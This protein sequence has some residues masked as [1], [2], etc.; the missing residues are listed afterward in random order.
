MNAVT[1]TNHLLGEITGLVVV[2][3]ALGGPEADRDMQAYPPQ[4]KVTDTVNRNVAK[5]AAING[6]PMYGANLARQV[7]D[8]FV[9]A[10]VNRLISRENGRHTAFATIYDAKL[11]LKKKT[12]KRLFVKSLANAGLWVPPPWGWLSA[13]VAYG[14]HL[15]MNKELLEFGIEY[16]ILEGL[17]LL[18]ANPVMREL[19]VKI[20]EDKLI[21]AIAAH[22][23]YLAGRPSLIGGRRP[24][25]TSSSVV[26]Y[27]IEQSLDHLSEVYHV[28]A[29]LFPTLKTQPLLQQLR[30]P[31]VQEAPPSMKGT[32][33]N[34]YE[35]P[36]DNDELA[37]D[38]PTDPV[39]EIREKMAENQ[40]KTERQIQQLKDRIEFLTNLENE[41]KDL[42]ERTGVNDEERKAF[43]DEQQKLSEMISK[44]RIELQE[45]E[46]DLAKI[47]EERR[48]MEQAFAELDKAPAGSG[49]PSAKEKHLALV[50]VPAAGGTTLPANTLRGMNQKEERYTQW[51]RA[52]YPYVDAF[53]APILALFRQRLEHSQAAKHYKKWTD[54]YTLIKAWQ[55]RS[56]Y[57]FR[58]T[59]GGGPDNDANGEWFLDRRQEPLRMYVMEEKFDPKQPSPVPQP[60]QQRVQKG[61]ERWTKD[62]DAGKEMAE[63]MLT[64]VA[65]THRDLKPLFSPAIYPAA[66]KNGV[67]TFAQAMYYNSNEQT[68]GE[69]GKAS[70][71]QAKV[72]WDTLNWNHE[73]PVPEWGTEAS[74][75][76]AKWPWDL[77]ESSKAWK[78][79]AGAKLNWQAKL[80]PVR[81]R[82]LIPAA[83]AA[84]FESRAMAEDAA[85]SLLFFDQMVTH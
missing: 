33:A 83:G 80:M 60:G 59:A 66:S 43:E 53:R 47:K 8:P 45:R 63:D 44:K 49:N 30:L 24:Q 78:G 57:R 36:W 61:F 69:Q 35:P 31:I 4:S 52:T 2:I 5:M 27:S 26:N 10:I 14:T 28:D 21:P 25:T 3:E 11:V 56:G 48:N 74:R 65:V 55:F 13:A 38:D 72:G 19:K 22:G 23:D 39:Q 76:S 46:K 71:S 32:A 54:R 64:I 1:A 81:K 70:T 29:S 62:T 75:S 84:V 79:H 68:P 17:E 73:K 34:Q 67:T 41:V 15:L 20:V 6:L 16:V 7:D 85:K 50:G 12:T 40:R 37:L 82:R 9:N 42:K 51:V 18:V 77:F 58:K